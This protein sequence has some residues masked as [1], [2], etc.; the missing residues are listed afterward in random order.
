MLAEC[1]PTPSG[2]WF[3]S[4]ATVLPQGTYI[5]Y[6][7]SDAEPRWALLRVTN[8]TSAQLDA[9]ESALSATGMINRL[10]RNGRRLGPVV[11]NQRFRAV[12]SGLGVDPAQFTNNSTGDD[13]RNAILAVHDPTGERRAQY[14]GGNLAVEE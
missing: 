14:T 10:A 8:D 7:R 2:R 4:P 1:E 12:L 6:F 3:A 9:A 13:V 11:N 5:R